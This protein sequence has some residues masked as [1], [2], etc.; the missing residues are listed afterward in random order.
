MWQWPVP[1]ELLK[2]GLRTNSAGAKKSPCAVPDFVYEGVPCYDEKRYYTG[3]LPS[4]ANLGFMF[5]RNAK[6]P[7]KTSGSEKWP[8]TGGLLPAPRGKGARYPTPSPAT[9]ARRGWPAQGVRTKAIMMEVVSARLGAGPTLPEA[10]RDWLSTRMRELILAK[11]NEVAFSVVGDIAKAANA[12]R[13]YKHAEGEHGYRC[14]IDTE[15]A[16]PGDPDSPT[17]Y[18]NLVEAGMDPLGLRYDDQVSLDLGANGAGRRAL[19]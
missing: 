11:A 13:R 4:A 12:H 10:M 18:V 6:G 1:D 16:I 9:G 14:Q 5:Q 19:C 8:A 15:E 17:V 7:F 3:P 2:K